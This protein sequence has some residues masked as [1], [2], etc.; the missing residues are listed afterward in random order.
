MRM[1]DAVVTISRF[2]RDSLPQAI[3]ELAR[4]IDNPFDTTSV[5]VDRSASREKLLG[6]A[7]SRES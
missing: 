5:P 6:R 4:I 7:G 1:A 2:C 3:G